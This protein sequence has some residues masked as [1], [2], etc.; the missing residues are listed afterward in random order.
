MTRRSL[1]VIGE[2]RALTGPEQPYWDSL[3]R[4]GRVKH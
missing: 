4:K 2:G 1:V 3:R